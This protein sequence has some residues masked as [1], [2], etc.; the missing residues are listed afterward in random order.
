MRTHQRSLVLIGVAIAVMLTSRSTALGLVQQPPR[1]LAFD[2]PLPEMNGKTLN[3]KVVDVRVAPG[4]ASAPHMHGCAVVVYV[5][6]GAMRMQVRG[7][8]E[9]VY[10]AGQTFF[11]KPTDI[12]QVSANASATDSAHFTATFVCDR[13]GPLTTPAPP[14]ESSPT[15]GNVR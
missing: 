7:G 3:M 15:P 11:E 4:A 13:V 1:P 5:I 12:H 9:N 6:S 14:T 8:P 2:Q 10:R